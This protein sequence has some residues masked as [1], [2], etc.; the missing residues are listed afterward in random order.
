LNGVVGISCNLVSVKETITCSLFWEA[1]A[2]NF[3]TT[4]VLFYVSGEENSFFFLSKMLE[5]DNSIGNAVT[6]IVLNS[7]SPSRLTTP[8]ELEMNIPDIPLSPK[9]V[10]TISPLSEEM[11]MNNTLSFDEVE[12]K[13][14]TLLLSFATNILL[15]DVGLVRNVAQRG[16]KVVYRIDHLEKLVAFSYL[17]GEEK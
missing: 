12:T 11:V 5:S 17:K 15:S 4:K 2:L 10:R 16:N 1:G 7:P 14:Q 13:S 8:N 9:K 6:L 3:V